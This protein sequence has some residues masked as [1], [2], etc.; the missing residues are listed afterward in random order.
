MTMQSLEV[1][2]ESEIVDRGPKSRA[3]YRKQATRRLT[4]LGNSLFNVTG[5][6]NAKPLHVDRTPQGKLI[7]TV[8]I[9]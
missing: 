8:I 5:R 9:C 6:T 7:G 3:F 1:L 2:A 4:G